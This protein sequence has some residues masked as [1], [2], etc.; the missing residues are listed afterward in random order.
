MGDEENS[1]SRKTKWLKGQGI[2]F[3]P[4]SLPAWPVLVISVPAT[5]TASSKWFP[6][7]TY[8]THLGS[9]NPTP[10]L[11]PS[12]PR[13]LEVPADMGPQGPQHPWFFFLLYSYFY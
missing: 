8:S 7:P 5:A 1:N 2:C 11:L 4:P 6:S 12:R 13:G 3:S 10:Y 9:T